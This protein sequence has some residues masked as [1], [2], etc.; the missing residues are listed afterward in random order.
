[1]RSRQWLELTYMIMLSMK[2]EGSFDAGTALAAFSQRHPGWLRYDRRIQDLL[3]RL[4][5]DGE[6]SL[7]ELLEISF[8]GV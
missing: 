2:A 8:E 7:D 4:P 5:A 6:C 3:A 1:M